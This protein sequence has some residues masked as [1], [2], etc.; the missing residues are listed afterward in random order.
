MVRDVSG[1]LD[2]AEVH[3]AHGC[4]TCTV[5]QDLIPELLRRSST[6]SLLIV[7]L[8]DS[9]EPR[10]VAETLAGQEASGRLYLACVHTA[11]DAEH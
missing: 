2:R 8:W 1:V 7:D 5:R 6:A 3:L 9:V 11:L 4:V 10:P